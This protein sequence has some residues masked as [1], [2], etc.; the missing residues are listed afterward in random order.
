M[1]LRYPATIL[2]IPILILA[3]SSCHSNSGSG[4]R[5]EKLE[6]TETGLHFSNDLTYTNQLNPYTY[7]NFY[8]GGGVAAGD[9]NNDGRIDLYFGGNSVD[10]KLYLNE[11]NFTFT[12]ITQQAGVASPDSWTT[13][14]TMADVNNDGYLDIYVC[15]SGNPDSPNR[16]NQL[17]INQG[18]NTFVDKAV[19]YNLDIKSLSNHAVFFDYDRDGDL[20]MYLL[21]N[22]FK[23]FLGMSMESG[24]RYK[25]DPDG[26]NALYENDNGTFKNVTQ[27]KGI[28]SSK[29]GFGL[30]VSISDIN[31]DGWPDIYISNDF[32]ERDYLYINQQ[33]KGFK[34]VLPKHMRSISLSSMG[35]DIADLNHDGYPEIYVTDMLPDSNRRLK[36]KMNFYPWEYQ[37]QSYEKGYHHQ[38]TR[39]TLQ[40]NNRDGTF[41]EISRMLDVHATDWSW[42]A[43]IADFD[44]NGYSDIFVANGIY[45]DLLDQDYLQKYSNPRAVRNVLG[46]DTAITKLINKMPSQPLS[47]HLFAGFDSLTFVNSAE[48]WGLGEPGFSNGSVY[49]DLD[50]DGDLDLVT[51]DVN[52]HAGVYRNTTIDK[53]PDLNWLQ[54]TLENKEEA[55]NTFAVGSKVYLWAD[56]TLYYRE[57]Y[58][59]RGFQSTVSHRLH[60][61][62]GKTSKIDS[63]MVVWPDQSVTTR[64]DIS[65][66]LN[67]ILTIKK[68][69]QHSTDWELSDSLTDD[70]PLIDVTDK[71]EFNWSHTENEFN[72]FDRNPLLFHMRSTEGPAFCVG[73]INSDNLDDFYLGGAKGQS[74]NLWVQQQSG[75]FKRVDNRAFTLDQDAEDTSCTFF[76]PDNDG[77]LDL[78]VTSGGMEFNSA[79][80]DLYDRI[81]INRNGQWVKGDKKM[82]NPGIESNSVVLSADINGDRADDLFVGTRMIPWR[83]GKSASGTIYINDGQGNYTDMTEKVAPEL[84]D[85]GLIKDA[86]WIDADNDND[87][88]L[89]VTGEWMKIHYFENNDGIFSKK[90]ENAGL[91]NTEGWWNRLAVADLNNDGN[92]DFIAGNHGTNTVLI[93]SKN[94]PLKLYVNDFDYNGSVDPIITKSGERRDYPVAQRNSMFRQLPMLKRSISS[95]EE[96]ATKTMS[97]LF[98]A[99]ILKE[100]EVK[101]TVQLESVI[102]WNNGDGTFT[103]ETLPKSE[104]ATP[105]YGLLPINLDDDAMLEI[106]S[107]G[108]LFEVKPFIGRYDA[109]YG[110]IVD[111]GPKG[112]LQSIKPVDSGFAID[113]AVRHIKGLRTAEGTLIIVVRN[114]QEPLFFNI[115]KQ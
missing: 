39:N 5:F 28:L 51:N 77:D 29:I 61:G 71:M 98:E 83:F 101:K 8:N 35:S 1:K 90:T 18:D 113:G 112:D 56:Q 70:P 40:L 60:V 33:G 59:A 7:R 88:D 16:K 110:T 92:V 69:S 43:L 108:N 24:Q 55:G 79:S 52:N 87:K 100:A 45:K 49:A 22:S 99:D 82:I 47:N 75:S 84:K 17:F 6:P 65:D 36:S 3:L 46:K 93:A 27:E 2:C 107:G 105:L 38:F 53:N 48:D 23:P 44:L 86:A 91:E 9:I 63:L 111:V 37:Q 34:E 26:G 15:K 41:S 81:Y 12:D 103:L 89:L 72:D 31:L 67:N 106:I 76:D 50:N 73:D 94:Q 95:Y 78:Y 20:D 14:V 96:Y 10:N 85:I 102:G 109:H 21:K 104:Q 66:H 57:L 11:G 42:A 19:E 74:G 80:S 54:I 115:H 32:F 68:D 13:G 114:N 58:P 97:Q 4:K 25:P 62:L 30:G 64:Y